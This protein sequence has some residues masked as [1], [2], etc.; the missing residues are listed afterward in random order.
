M[1][2]TDDYPSKPPECKFVKASNGKPLFHP[3]V[4]PSGK[5]CLSLL[6]AEKAWKPALTIKQLLIGIQALLD[7]PNNNDPAQEEPYRIFK[8]DRAEYN[9]RVK[10]QVRAFFRDRS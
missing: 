6:D 7:D 4:Y 8:S 1:T 3:N 5:I 2:F 10:E 9:R